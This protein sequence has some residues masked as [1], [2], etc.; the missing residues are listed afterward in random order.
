VRLLE[1]TQ[2]EAELLWEVL[3]PGAVHHHK[4][5]LDAVLRRMEPADRP[6]R[7]INPVLPDGPCSLELSDAELE[8]IREWLERRPRRYVGDPRFAA[9]RDRFD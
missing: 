1:L 8:K 3:L 9:L 7:F 5:E 2:D 6:A 4:P